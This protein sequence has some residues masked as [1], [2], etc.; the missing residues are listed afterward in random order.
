VSSERKRGQRPSGEVRKD[1]LGLIATVVDS[2]EL[3]DKLTEL[4]NEVSFGGLTYAWGPI[5]Y[6]KS[7]TLF[8][9]FILSHF[10]TYLIE[11][12]WRF[13]PVQWKGDVAAALEPWLEEVDRADDVE[14][15]RR[16]Y[17][18]KL[19]RLSHKKAVAQWLKDLAQ[20]ALDSEGSLH[21][22]LSKMESWYW[23]DEPTAI[24]LYQTHPA[25]AR[26]FI[27]R[28]LPKP[29]GVF[30]GEKRE[31][32]RRLAGL[33][34]EAGD[35]EFYFKLYRQQI[36]IKDWHKEVVELCRLTRDTQELLRALRDRHPAT[37]DKNLGDVFHDLLEIRGKE[38]FPY[39][40]PHLRQVHRG[41]F[42]P[43]FK[44]LI[45]LA[46]KKEWRSLWAGLL[47]SCSSPKEF[48]KAVLESLNKGDQEARTRLALLGG[49]GHEW[50][51]GP[52]SLARVNILSDKAAL[53]VYQRFPELLAG[54]LKSCLSPHPQELYPK[55]L[56]RLLEQDDQDLLDYLASRLVTRG[57]SPYEE[58]LLNPAE[59]LADYYEKLQSNDKVFAARA[60]NVLSQ[61][62]AFAV[63]SYQDL[64][65]K[66]RLARLF[67]ARSVKSYLADERA[68][69]DLLESPE[70][71]A[72]ILA[73]RALAL[74]TDEARK[75]AGKNLTILLG[76]LLRP[77][78]RRTRLLAFKALR[79]A[80][81]DAN[82]AA[83]VLGK[84]KEAFDLPDI[85]YPKD[86]LVALI[87]DILHRFPEMREE[88][89]QPVIY[90]AALC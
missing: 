10:S 58:K 35:E 5:L 77:I 40:L 13:K 87:G 2:V 88:E 25:S 15:F 12:R 57:A 14:I 39:V 53:A 67:Y 48:E 19:S 3:R 52:F 78:H 86:D 79:N 56:D 62:P 46:E 9:P 66:N 22:E 72:Q 36:P 27:L 64:I 28:H 11:K 26:P 1:A 21:T 61:V 16:L 31:F 70:I 55:L 34:K 47:R 54:P 23:L 49:V 60:G 68:L 37:W 84:A 83:R 33:A 32:W 29:W 85:R 17:G 74:N 59:H 45:E 82:K 81:H 18:W 42:N 8:R 50:N 75:I 20:R 44:R 76:T 30:S 41:W 90:G 6:R 43:S 4:S 63:W 89:E 24:T 69:Q 7:P 80:A 38:L 51:F 73:Y 71:H 65:R